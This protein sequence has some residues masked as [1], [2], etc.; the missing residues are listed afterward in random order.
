PMLIQQLTG[1]D[2]NYRGQG[3]GKWVKAAML[4]KVREKFPDIETISTA[5]ASSN[6]PMLAI[7]ER[8]GFKLNKEIFN[9]QIDTEKL[10][11]YL[12]KK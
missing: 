2:Q 9:V 6:A 5:N 8:L 1:V 7:N 10:G 3:K 12:A 4:L 11:E